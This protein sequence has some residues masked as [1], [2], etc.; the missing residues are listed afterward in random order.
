MLQYW[1]TK[2][3]N[4]SDRDIF[5]ETKFEE[6]DLTNLLKANHSSLYPVHFGHL[7]TA[8][9]IF[10]WA[11]EKYIALLAIEFD[12]NIFLDLLFLEVNVKITP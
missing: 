7:S 3:R 9:D 12:E 2:Y 8:S 5:F 10:N 11:S 4:S 6:P 1:K